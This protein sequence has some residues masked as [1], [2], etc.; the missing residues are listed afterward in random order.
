MKSI[1]HNLYQLLFMHGADANC[2]TWKGGTASVSQV[3]IEEVHGEERFLVFQRL[4]KKSCL[5]S[6][7]LSP[8]FNP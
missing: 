7:E 2:G 4:Y 3:D 1:V 6:K 8:T 5:G